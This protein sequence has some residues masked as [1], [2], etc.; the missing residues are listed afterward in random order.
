MLTRVELG[1]R[2]RRSRESAG[3]SQKEAATELGLP[4]PAIS[5][6]EAGK[7]G[8]DTLELA[9]LARLY[10]KPASWFLE[11]GTGANPLEIVT[12]W[13]TFSK[14][15]QELLSGFVRFCEDYGWIEGVLELSPASPLPD[16]GA[17]DDPAD[18]GEAVCQG[19]AVAEAERRRLGLGGI[20]GEGIGSLLDRLGIRL[21]IRHLPACRVQSA[22]LFHPRVGAAI[23][24]NAGCRE[25]WLPLVLMEEYGH[26]LFD[27]RLGGAIHA[28]PSE[29]GKASHDLRSIR[30]H[31]FA[32]A[33]VLPAPELRKA[34]PFDPEARSEAGH[35]LGV[36]DLL[37][38]EQMFRCPKKVLWERWEQ[39]GWVRPEQWERF[40]SVRA[41]EWSRRFEGRGRTEGKV[42]HPYPSRFL[43]L[44]LEG[45][46]KGL[47]SRERLAILL[48]LDPRRAGQLMSW[49]EKC[50]RSGLC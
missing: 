4:R 17:A 33:F 1:Q 38:L 44:V 7:R 30:A 40:G 15:D 22:F 49:L 6:I 31:R 19:E 3:L 10:G 12:Q 8:V 28:T 45:C 50:A 20:C 35:H 13:E 46:K 26:L 43:R 25:K 34:L 48:D 32:S 11:P 2:L 16:Y 18:E 27:R 36:P 47:V 39:L 23:F 37:L 21:S 41:A 29:E 14:A 24:G 42:D 9:R 5:Q